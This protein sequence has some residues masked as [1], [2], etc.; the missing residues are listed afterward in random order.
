MVH[1]KNY[2]T[3]STVKRLKVKGLNIYIPPLT[4]NP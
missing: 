4:G 1:A 2:E 3:A